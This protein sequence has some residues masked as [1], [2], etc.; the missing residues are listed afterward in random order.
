MKVIAMSKT[1]LDVKQF[2]DVTK[3]EVI[4]NGIDIQITYGSSSTQNYSR[5]SHIISIIES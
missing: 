3:I 4:N 1:T 2:N 5:A